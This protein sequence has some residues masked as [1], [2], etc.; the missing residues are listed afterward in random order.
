MSLYPSSPD[1]FVN[2]TGVDAIA[3]SDP[4]NAYEA[5]EAIQGLL[6]NAGDSQSHSLDVMDYLSK[7]TPPIC[8]KKDLNTITV[9]AG[10]VIIKNAAGTTRL[11][12]RNPS[13][14]DVVA[15][16]L[17][18]GAMADATYYYIYA[19]ADSAATTFTLKFSLSATTP[20]G[21]TN[22]ELIGWFY[23]QAAGS[24]TITD[25]FVGNMKINGRDV[26]N[27]IRMSY[28]ANIFASSTSYVDL[29]P[30]T[31]RFISNGRPLLLTCN[32][33]STIYSSTASYGWIIFSLDSSTYGQMSVILYDG[34]DNVAHGVFS[35]TIVP[36]IVAGTHSIIIQAKYTGGSGTFGLTGGTAPIE[37]SVG[38][39]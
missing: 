31:A 34:A 11:L 15:A 19:V 18:T 38:E 30:L 20:T 36:G 27:A 12:R 17:D 33:P 39:L 24:L 6:G 25:G 21:L 13:D 28:A 35:S 32:I 16:N 4:N 26:P 22:Y 8:V 23:N 3:S 29:S 5:I 14:T 2:R 1:V 7:A 9:K 10:S 37:L